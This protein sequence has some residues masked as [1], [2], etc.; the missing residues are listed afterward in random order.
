MREGLS[1]DPEGKALSTI[2]LD[3]KR[4]L[5]EAEHVVLRSHCH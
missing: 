4:G 1:T 2:F 3:G 5:R